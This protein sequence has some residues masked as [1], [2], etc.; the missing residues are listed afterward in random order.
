MPRVSLAG[1]GHCV[2]FADGKYGASERLVVAPGHEGDGIFH[3][4]GGQSGQP[5][6]RHYFDQQESWIEGLA[7]RFS[8]SKI[9]HKLMLMPVPH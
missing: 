5:G 6:S 2:R 1:C 9:A 8:E 7:A 3:M 4:P